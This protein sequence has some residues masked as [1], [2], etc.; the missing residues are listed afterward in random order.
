MWRLLPC[1]KLSWKEGAIRVRGGRSEE[2][3]STS[4]PADIPSFA[5]DKEKGVAVD[6]FEFGSDVDPEEESMFDESFTWVKV[7]IEG[8]TRSI[9]IPLNCD[10]LTNTESAVPSLVPLCSGA[11]PAKWVGLT[12]FQIG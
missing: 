2:Y 1:Q 5:E 12:R 7:R 3:P 4:E 9:V 6:D 11:K 8:F 10:L